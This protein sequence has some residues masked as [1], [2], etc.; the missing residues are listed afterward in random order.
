MK[1]EKGFLPLPIRQFAALRNM[2]NVFTILRFKYRAYI[3]YIGIIFTVKIIMHPCT[4]TPNAPANTA[5]L[6]A[7]SKSQFIS[8]SAELGS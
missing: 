3:F 7:V 1:T 4:D 5:N 2:C 8:V 6:E